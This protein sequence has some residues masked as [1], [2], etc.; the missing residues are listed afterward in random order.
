MPLVIAF[1]AGC[2]TGAAGMIAIAFVVVREVESYH[3]RRVRLIRDRDNWAL[4]TYYR[5]G[6][7][8]GDGGLE[9]PV[10]GSPDTEA[11][12]RRG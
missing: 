10:E 7:N 6:V 2:I 12:V 11:A 1:I 5:W 9:D 3:F 8:G 4:S